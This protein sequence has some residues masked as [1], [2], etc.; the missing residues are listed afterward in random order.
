MAAT[1]Y[2]RCKHANVCVVAVERDNS[3]LGA[4]NIER[5]CEVVN[6]TLPFGRSERVFAQG[7]WVIDHA[8]VLSDG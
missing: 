8:G 6:A 5:C 1:R 7:S 2:A 4:G 3:H